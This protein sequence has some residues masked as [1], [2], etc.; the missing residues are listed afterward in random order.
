M[1][2]RND[3]RH[4]RTELLERDSTEPVYTFVED[5]WKK[6]RK[7]RIISLDFSPELRILQKR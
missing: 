2:Y 5:A 3:I 7:S 6:G 1:R 4:T